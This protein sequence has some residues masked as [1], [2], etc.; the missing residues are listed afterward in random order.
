VAFSWQQ[1]VVTQEAKTLFDLSREL[2]GRLATMA[3]HIDKLGRS[4]KATVNDYNRFV[5]SLERQVLPS[6]RKLNVLDESKAIPPLTEIEDAARDLS[7]F[8]LLGELEETTIPKEIR[9]RA[10]ETPAHTPD[11]RFPA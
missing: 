3:G 9:D 7:A 1:D 5:G 6:A 4:V 2:Y 11:E 8:E 10:A